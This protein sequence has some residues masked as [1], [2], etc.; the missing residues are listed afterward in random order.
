[1][2]PNTTTT[3]ASPHH[4]KVVPRKL[5]LATTTSKHLNT[6]TVVA[7][8]QYNLLPCLSRLPSVLLVCL[9]SFWRR[10][11]YPCRIHSYTTS[12]PTPIQ[13]TAFE[14]QSSSPTHRCRHVPHPQHPYTVRNTATPN[15]PIP[16]QAAKN[17]NFSHTLHRLRTSEM[18]TS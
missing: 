6:L 14:I 1:M 18:S 5:L 4:P 17:C 2:V 11:F 10:I 3:K 7:S 15:P 12:V 16:S 13:S 8:L 9:N